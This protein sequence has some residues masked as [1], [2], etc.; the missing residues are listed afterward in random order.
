MSKLKLAYKNL[1]KL[2]GADLARA[3]GYTTTFAAGS[4][5]TMSEATHAGGVILLDTAAGSTVTLPASSGQ[6]AKYTFIVSTVATSN[7]HIIKVAN[8][9]DAMQGHILSSDDTSD[10]AVAFAA[11]AGTSDTIT[12]NRTTTG[13]IV[14]GE[15]IEIIDLASNVFQV[16]GVIS[17]TGTPATP[18]SATV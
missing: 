2:K 16:N 6:G 5:L 4:A 12:L 3:G 15:H 17:N 9:S 10:N 8:S 1:N 11:T 18:F 13:S 14:K 7:S